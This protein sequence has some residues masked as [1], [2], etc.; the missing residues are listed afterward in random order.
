MKF[1][2]NSNIIFYQFTLVKKK[3]QN[4]TNISK[5]VIFIYV[6][7]LNTLYYATKQ[8]T[9]NNIV[10]FFFDKGMYYYKYYLSYTSSQR[11]T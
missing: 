4:T 11:E 2:T 1:G 3:S 5:F 9:I 7:K 6:R 10:I 8:T